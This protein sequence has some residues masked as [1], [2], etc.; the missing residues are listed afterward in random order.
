[1]FLDK[2]YSIYIEDHGCDYC[3][4][5]FQSGQ[6]LSYRNFIYFK[7]ILRSFAATLKENKKNLEEKFVDS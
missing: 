3:E 7:K 1:M 2:I 6:F 5:N 4:T